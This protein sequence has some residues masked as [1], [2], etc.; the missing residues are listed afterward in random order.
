MKK[1]FL[2]TKLLNCPG[3]SLI[4]N[5]ILHFRENSFS[6]LLERGLSPVAVLAHCLQAPSC[7]GNRSLGR[8]RFCSNIYGS[9]PF[10]TPV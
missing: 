9:V 2:S 3:L 1:R 6:S 10:V 7:Q 8:I 5:E 4:S